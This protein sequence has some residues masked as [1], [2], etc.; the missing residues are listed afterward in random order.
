M[1]R[2]VLTLAALAAVAAPLAVATNAAAQGRYEGREWRE[3]RGRDND[4]WDRGDRWE[5][6]GDYDR[7][8][9]RRWDNDNRRWDRD[10]RRWDND[11]RRWD[12]R[13][14]NGYY[15]G[16]R[17]YYGQPR[18]TYYNRYDYRPAYR[19]WQRGAYLPPAY[20]GYVIHDYPRYRLRHPPRGYHWVR[21]NN[22]YILSAIAT[23]L[24]LEV[25]SGNY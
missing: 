11:R 10:N 24:I 2:L 21:H 7:H 14:Y 9:N 19:P 16:N 6:R 12:N 22:D 3:D 8:D 1:K 25:I 13:R 23:G 5:R 4:R 17:W 20:R 15:L 18:V